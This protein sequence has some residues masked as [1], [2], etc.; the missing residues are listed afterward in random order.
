MLVS[1]PKHRFQWGSVKIKFWGFSDAHLNFSEL[2]SALVGVAWKCLQIKL[3]S[4]FPGCYIELN[5]C[6]F[7][8]LKFWNCLAN[9][10][11][12]TETQIFVMVSEDQILR[13]QWGSVKFQWI[14]I[15]S[16]R[17]S[18]GMFANQI[19]LWLS[20][21]LYWSNFLLL[22]RSETG[23]GNLDFG[24]GLVRLRFQWIL[25]LTTINLL[26]LA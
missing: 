3:H 5:F 26:Y 2:M 25:S 17:G 12:N 15:I 19:T 1:A 21:L 6:N 20:R 24:E 10:S 4:N 11:L 8:V 9:V 13:F 23:S 14:N 16:D 18:L 7:E 22:R